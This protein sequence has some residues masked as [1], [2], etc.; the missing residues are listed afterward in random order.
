MLRE[1][2]VARGIDNPRVLQAL[3]SVPREKFVPP[4]C[5]ESAYDDRALPIDC[6][7]TISQ[8]FIVALMTQSLE[9]NGYEHV[10]EIGTG[11]GYQT[12]ILCQLAGDV[13][14]IERHSGLSAR[15]GRLLHELGCRNQTLIVG[16]GS[17]GHADLAPYDRIIVTAAARGIPPML[18]GQL[19]EGGTIVIPLGGE[20]SQMLRAIRK[21]GGQ[22]I[23]RD[24]SPCRFVPLIGESG[25]PPEQGPA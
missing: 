17:Q 18:W 19:A 3:A 13:V 20:D 24:L 4:D 12:A 25:W 6:D 1:H 7:Q 5:Q 16:D 2:L 11:S 9:L 14:S 23:A 10:L 22:A 21:L 15:A 8:P